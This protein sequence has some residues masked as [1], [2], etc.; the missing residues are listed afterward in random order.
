MRSLLIG[1]AVVVIAVVLVTALVHVL[2]YGFLFL[3]AIGIGFVA[4][5]VGR[6]TGGRNRS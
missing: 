2:H 4:F 3:V 5:R 6:R 1:L